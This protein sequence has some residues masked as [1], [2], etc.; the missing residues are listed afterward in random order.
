MTRTE[1]DQQIRELKSKRNAAVSEIAALQS[2]I[3]EE[4]AAKNRTI[5]EFTREIQKLKQSLQGYHQR[6]IAIDN[7]WNIKINAFIKENEPST[8]SNLAESSTLNIIYELRRRGYMGIV[9][10]DGA[11]ESESELYDLSKEDWN[12]DKEE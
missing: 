2:E 3:K 9:Q 5:Q 1:F 4:I 8:T 7:E 10:K 12:H 6:R 11:A